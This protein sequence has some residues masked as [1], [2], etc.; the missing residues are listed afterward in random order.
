MRMMSS[1]EAEPAK[2][3]GKVGA[4][5]NKTQAI[6]RKKP[7][8]TPRRSA[9]STPNKAHHRRQ[10]SPQRQCFSYDSVYYVVE[11]PLTIFLTLL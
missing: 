3:I 9:L 11:Q 6:P 7:A 1:E 8:G 10:R 5:Q 2:R 4:R